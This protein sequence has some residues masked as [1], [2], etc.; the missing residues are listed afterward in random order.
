M[1]KHYPRL[2]HNEKLIAVEIH[3]QV[4]HH[5]VRKINKKEILKK[6]IIL[7]NKAQI[8]D[9]H[10][11]MVHNLLN[12]QLNDYGYFKAIYSFRSIYDILTI[13]KEKTY[14]FDK[15]Y[16]KIVRYYFIILDVLL[17]THFIKKY[18]F[19][20]ILYKYRFV[21]KK[22]YKFMFRLDSYFSNLFL[23]IY[24]LPSKIFIKLFKENKYKF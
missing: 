23:L 11:Q 17:T 6:K 10:Y 7:N 14:F 2:L 5:N 15:N 3:E 20:E 22:K 12:Y 16:D 1:S 13:I 24:L 4:L 18:S 19:Y 8:S 9:N 21:L